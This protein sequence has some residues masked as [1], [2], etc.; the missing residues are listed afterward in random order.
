M[1]PSLFRE[2]PQI[3]RFA[4][5]FVVHFLNMRLTFLTND[6]NFDS[7]FFSFLGSFFS[8]LVGFGEGEGEGDAVGVG[9]AAFAFAS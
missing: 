8:S 4:P 3:K 7:F 6:P 9:E 5:G 2:V 1:S